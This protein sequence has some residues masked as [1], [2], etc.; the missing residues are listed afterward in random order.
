MG[1]NPQVPDFTRLYL[2][3]TILR[4]SNWPHVSAE[5]T[6]LLEL[7]RNF[8][9]EVFIPEA[10]EIEREAQ[11][12]RD[13]G[14][15]SQKLG[16]AADKLALSLEAVASPRI[17]IAPRDLDVLRAAFKAQ[18]DAAKAANEI[19][20]IPI[21]GRSVPEFLRLA[22]ER[23]PPFQI[24]G[25]KVTGFQ[26]TVIFFSVLDDAKAS[27]ARNCAIISE[28]DV[29]SKVHQI[30]KA[31][32][33]SLKH[34]KSIHDVWALLVDEISPHVLGWW[35]H[36]KA[37]I[38]RVLE[39]QISQIVRVL[40]ERITPEMVAY[41]AEKVEE[42]ANLRIDDVDMPIPDF[43][44]HPGPYQTAE[45]AMFR[46]SI[47]LNADFRVQAAP[48][49]SAL[50]AVEFYRQMQEGSVGPTELESQ[51]SLKE[52]KPETLWKKIEMEANATYSGERY[53]VSDL[54]FVRIE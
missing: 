25:D 46:V 35:R 31:E 54:E 30:A 9:I 16:A 21:T 45:G 8:A 41:R 39:S 11:W 51:R 12:F 4:R 3:T 19:G 10:V 29:F 15:A 44:H 33:I 34:F 2:D 7:A 53:N 17:D 50:L 22:I 52:L 18:S 6:F 43:P 26:D 32:Q 24:S 28:D 38:R 37:E 36:E 14:S 27:G 40:W 49:L 5:L 23:T 20:I 47:K 48:G 42:I 1:Y 13:L